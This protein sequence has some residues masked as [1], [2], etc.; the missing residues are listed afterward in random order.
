MCQMLECRVLNGRG[1]GYIKFVAWEAAQEAIANLNDR[2]VAG[3]QLPLRV[4][5]AT[6]K[7]V[8]PAQGGPAPRLEGGQLVMQA[9]THDETHVR[10]QGLDPRRLFVGQIERNLSDRSILQDKG[11]CY[12]QYSTFQAAASA[13]ATLQHQVL[14]GVSSPQGLNVKF[15]NISPAR[16]GY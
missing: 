1:C 13:L 12:V 5:W 15:S 2:S 3:W 4:R 7:G 10:S 6:P 11:I 9:P 8:P 16:R 14:P